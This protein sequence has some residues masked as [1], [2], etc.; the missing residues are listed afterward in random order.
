VKSLDKA[1]TPYASDVA[2]VI[3]DI[4]RIATALERIAEAIE[5][6]ANAAAF[7]DAALQ[8]N[9]SEEPDTLDDLDWYRTVSGTFRIRT[10]E[11]DRFPTVAEAE[12]L[13]KTLSSRR[14]RSH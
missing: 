14:K 10:R 7:L 2:V 13:E 8:P 1:Y 5:G 3:Q 4:G 11:G 6:E 12:R 9:P